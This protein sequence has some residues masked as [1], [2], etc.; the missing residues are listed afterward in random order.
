MDGT[1]EFPGKVIFRSLALLC[2]EETPVEDAFDVARQ[3]Q[4]NE[5]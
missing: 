5:N 1:E 4:A 2:S 3:N